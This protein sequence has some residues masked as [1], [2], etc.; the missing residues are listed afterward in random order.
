MCTLSSSVL[1]LSNASRPR[2]QRPSSPSARASTI[3]DSDTTTAKPLVCSFYW[4]DQS[5]S[6]IA[7]GLPLMERVNAPKRGGEAAAIETKTRRVRVDVV[8][9]N[10]SILRA[11]WPPYTSACGW[12]WCQGGRHRS[13]MSIVLRERAGEEWWGLWALTGLCLPQGC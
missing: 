1:A 9:V 7:Q 2:Q 11:Q 5:D 4:A 13:H 6:F 12:M 8:A 3:H 10:K